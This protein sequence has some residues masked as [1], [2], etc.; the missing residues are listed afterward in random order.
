MSVVYGKKG[1]INMGRLMV[2]CSEED[3]GEPVMRRMSC[4]G[5]G[6]A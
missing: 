5:D 3:E 4:A 6:G 2:R 1:I